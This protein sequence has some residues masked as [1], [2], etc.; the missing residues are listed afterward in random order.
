M[1]VYLGLT[2]LLSTISTTNYLVDNG[3]AYLL[4]GNE[5]RV[6]S[7][8]GSRKLPLFG[9]PTTILLGVRP[10][11][12][13]SQALFAIDP[14]KEEIATAFRLDRNYSDAVIGANERI[15]LLG[16]DVLS[17]VQGSETKMSILYTFALPRLAGN[18]FKLASGS[19]F[20]TPSTGT[21]GFTF[22][23]NDKS[24]SDI[25]LPWDPGDPVFV[26]NVLVD[27]DAGGLRTY[28]LSS[29]SKGK[30]DLGSEPLLL[31][32]WRGKVLAAT[33]EEL[34]F[35]D[36]GS[37]AVA[38][39]ASIPAIRKIAAVDE[40]SLA[41]V[42]TGNDL[43]TLRLPSLAVLDTF[44]ASCNTSS[45]AYPFLAQP[46]FVC[47]DKLAMPGGS[48]STSGH[49]AQDVKT[50]EG[51]FFAL[52]VGAFSDPMSF[53]PL[54]ERL[55]NQGLPY[56]ALEEGDL[57]KF[58]VGFFPNREAADRIRG[59]LDDLGTWIVVEQT[60]HPL[61]QSIHDINYDG[62]RTD[63]IVSK[64]DSVYIFTLKERTW[65]EVIKAARLAEPVTEVYL[66]G[67]HVYA[68]LQH[69][70]LRELVLPDSAR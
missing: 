56:Y 3:K 20:F 38:A 18:I 61:T 60:A 62:R 24:I 35:A 54:L 58:R 43:I 10:Y 63:G 50:Q 6:I 40:D 48:A 55:A 16:A 37:Q 14:P 15:Y 11:V 70:G 65:I 29:R 4:D 23:P 64:Q 19:L 49:L 51:K 53:G 46:L 41:V 26:N 1:K 21:A 36:P 34:T 25:T 39:R 5:L 7:P 52:Q 2:I 45:A 17:V 57:T 69:S 27:K 31:S 66:K 22:N 12:L 59:C 44:N 30:I 47:G 68:R 28:N 67:N 42:L 33:A 13:T 32:I 8:E 9:V